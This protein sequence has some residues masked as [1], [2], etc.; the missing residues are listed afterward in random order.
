M[1]GDT[2]QII[3]LKFLLIV[4]VAEAEDGVDMHEL[5]EDMALECYIHV[6]ALIITLME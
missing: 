5:A 2:F 4:F 6:L 3:P 1:Y